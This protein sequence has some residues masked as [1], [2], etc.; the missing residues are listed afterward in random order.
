MT[1]DEILGFDAEINEEERLPLEPG[2]YVF[3]VKAF[4]PSASQSSGV[5]LSMVTMLLYSPDSPTPVGKIRDWF[6]MTRKAEWKICAYFRTI[7]MKK[8]GQPLRM[9]WPGSVGKF[10]I[11]QIIEEEYNRNIRAKVGAYIDNEDVEDL[12][13]IS[14][15]ETFRKSAENKAFRTPQQTNENIDEVEVPF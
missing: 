3:K 4:E 15:L 5:P 9:D 12:K 6:P 11:C 7:G 13:L 8:H 2:L 10:G 14:L 1:T